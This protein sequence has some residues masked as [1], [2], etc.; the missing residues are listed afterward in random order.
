MS[1]PK[2]VD[3]ILIGGASS[4]T[5][6]ARIAPANAQFT[7]LVLERGGVAVNDDTVQ[8]PSKFASHL[9]PGA[10]YTH[11]VEAQLDQRTTVIAQG[12][13]VGGSSIINGTVYSRGSKSEFD[14]WKQ[15]GWRFNDLL[16]YFKKVEDYHAPLNDKDLHGLDGNLKA[17]NSPLKR[18]VCA[19]K[20]SRY[21]EEWLRIVEE[22]GVPNTKDF[23]DFNT[24]NGCSTIKQFKDPETG[25]RSDVAHSLLY[26]LRPHF[27]PPIEALPS[28]H[29]SNVHIVYSTEASRILLRNGKA[30][31]VEFDGR[32][33]RA[34]RLV[35]LSAGAL[36]SPLVLERSGIGKRNVL[37]SAG[38][39]LKVENHGVG[40]N[41]MDHIGLY[42]FYRGPVDDKELQL[43]D[44]TAVGV[45][46]GAKLSMTGQ[47]VQKTSPDF[48]KH[49]NRSIHPYPDRAMC[50]IGFA[51][52]PLGD[53]T[54]FGKGRF[55]T[56]GGYIN[57]LSSRG[58][59]H[60]SGSAPESK[61]IFKP[62][63]STVDLEGL[64]WI[65]KRS[66]EI[67]RRLSCYRG[68]PAAAH[69]RFPP[70]SPASIQEFTDGPVPFDEKPIVYSDEDEEA[71][72]QYVSD[73]LFYTWHAAG[74]CA[75]GS[76]IDN[77]LNVLGVGNLKV[78]DM[79]ILPAHVGANTYATA[80]MIGEKAA[81][82]VAEDFSLALVK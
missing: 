41:Y 13:A 74:T 34:R 66:R 36:A 35:I 75:I 11:F 71:L 45:D 38:I 27:Y 64:A 39:E 70:G 49:W 55:Y 78:V 47:E 12:N 81:S 52:I 68:E 58:S 29:R 53:P 40:E 6:L 50:W 20:T 73:A 51:P 79:S 25:V 30:D 14:E 23:H 28:D 5:F 26:P 61:P 54:P 37:E 1:Y 56:C 48:Q 32:V 62:G 67:N 65:Y 8:N 42:V 60:I 3:Y 43:I 24:S 33:I 22:S 46:A 72:I 21:A 9:A 76:V 69:P 59:I 80:C 17:S 4:I 2:E 44:D 63:L 18:W 7:F 10:K 19:T 15:D 77:R 82:I 31:G 16:P 57:H